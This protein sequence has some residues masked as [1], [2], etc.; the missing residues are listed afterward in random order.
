MKPRSV[1]TVRPARSGAATLA[2]LAAALLIGSG[3]VATSALGAETTA[4]QQQ[5]ANR[6]ASVK[7]MTEALRREASKAGIDHNALLGQTAAQTKEAEA[8]AA[9]GK[10]AAAQPLL[11]ESYRK[12]TGA[13]AGIKRAA[14]AT[15]ATPAGAKPADSGKQRERLARD[16]ATAGTMLDA[17]KR[18]NAEKRGG[19][20]GE[21][22]A[23]E[24]QRRDVDSALKAGELDR[25]DALNRDAY[26]RI[27]TA[28]ASL[29]PATDLKSGSA[30][31]AAGGRE[32]S[33]AAD[34][35]A[36]RNYPRRR[37]SALSLIETG[38]RIAAEK[39]ATR[40]EFAQAEGLVKE[41]EGLANSGKHAEGL[42]RV[43]RAY[44]LARDAVRNL[45]GG[46]ELTAGRGFASKADEFRYE[47]SRND[48][49]QGLI[50]GV[51]EGQ[52]DPSWA[53]AA[54]QAKRLR[55]E[56]EKTA[57]GGDFDAA[58]RKIEESTN[59]L[60]DILRRAGFPII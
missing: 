25:A 10:F 8:L 59:A 33:I 4:E 7:A 54:N 49:Y 55:S 58:L 29:Q 36:Q 56:A 41:A 39:R 23:I 24:N 14:P 9:S 50:G 34:A 15:A 6:L 30:A 17:L 45:R 21:I 48:D 53:Q 40:P 27:K 57:K 13:I 44:L 26:L 32:P 42:L 20:D 38:K 37:D 1:H 35:A 60:K 11:E 18:Q 31:L 3:T 46:E 2:V 51:I 12:L 5:F 16:I 19:K 22:A 43:D 47:Q 28:I 52:S